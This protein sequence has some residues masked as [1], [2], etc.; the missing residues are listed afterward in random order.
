M[1]TIKTKPQT[2]QLPLSPDRFLHLATTIQ[3]M[4]VGPTNDTETS[5]CLVKVEVVEFANQ[6]VFRKVIIRLTP[7]E[8]NCLRESINSVVNLLDYTSHYISKR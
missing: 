3:P 1:S 6:N 2:L 5:F 8:F 4:A 7:E